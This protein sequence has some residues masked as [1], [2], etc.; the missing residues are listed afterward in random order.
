MLIVHFQKNIT[1]DVNDAGNSTAF[2]RL[3]QQAYECLSDVHKRQKYDTAKLFSDPPSAP[4][5]P[6]VSETTTEHNETYYEPVF[7]TVSQ[8][9]V[10]EIIKKQEKSVG[11][12][13]L[14]VLLFLLKIP[15]LVLI[16]IAAFISFLLTIFATIAILVIRLCLVLEIVFSGYQTYLTFV[17]R[18]D[19][20]LKELILLWVVGLILFILQYLAAVAPAVFSIARDMLI[21]FVFGIT[22]E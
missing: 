11:N 20:P 5:P 3:I 4:P 18:S 6:S 2:F 22:F 17:G 13:L 10:Q 19:L 1:P 15:A 7:K 16:P 9:D 12:V 8:E 21:K 14:K